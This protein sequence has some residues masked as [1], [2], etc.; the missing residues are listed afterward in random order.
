MLRQP[1]HI[2]QHF[3]APDDPDSDNT[4]SVIPFLVISSGLRYGAVGFPVIPKS[5]LE[6]P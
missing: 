2:P 4:S 6:I 1:A 5:A 3:K